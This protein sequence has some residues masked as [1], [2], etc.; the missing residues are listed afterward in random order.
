MEVVHVVLF[1][2]WLLLF[3]V[4][5]GKLRSDNTRNDEEEEKYAA[6]EADN[7]IADAMTEETTT[8]LEDTTT[9]PLAL[10]R[11]CAWMSSSHRTVFCD[12]YY[13][14]IGMLFN[15][16]AVLTFF[17]LT[18][19][20][21]VYRVYIRSLYE[22]TSDGYQRCRD[23]NVISKGFDKLGQVHGARNE[24]IKAWSSKNV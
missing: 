14:F 19:S 21:F 10:L 8:R 23:Y 13:T 16:F 11:N 3:E 4:Y 20:N 6:S 17:L 24:N 7:P 12:R 5:Q 15:T 22:D 9:G 1:S 18:Y 2:H